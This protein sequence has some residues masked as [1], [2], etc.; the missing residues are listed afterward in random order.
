MDSVGLLSFCTVNYGM[1]LVEAQVE[2]YLA[3]E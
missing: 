3:G 1:E 2:Q